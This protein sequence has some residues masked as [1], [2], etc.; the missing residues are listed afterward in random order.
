MD[1]ARRKKPVWK[2]CRPYEPNDVTFWKGKN[3]WDGEE[4]SG[5]GELV[6]EAQGFRGVVQ[7]FCTVL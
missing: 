4:I 2:G 7:L 6:G 1:I 3:L 5:C